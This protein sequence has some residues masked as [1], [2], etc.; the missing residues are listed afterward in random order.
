MPEGFMDDF[1]GRLR[2]PL[3]LLLLAIAVGGAIDLVL[4]R[5]QHLFSLHT[6]YEIG[7]VLGAS[8]TAVWL[9]RGWHRA[10]SLNVQLRRTLVERQAERDAWRATAERA[11]TGLG[12]AIGA[13]FEAWGLSPAEREVALQLLK[14]KSHK[15]IAGETGRSERTVR[16]HA[17]TAYEKAGLGGRA[18]LAAYFLEGLMLPTT[19]P[20]GGSA[21]RAPA[22]AERGGQ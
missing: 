8:A 3:T 16:Q 4:D 18:E 12:A 13:Q 1:N 17:A 20:S 2:F 15:E 10:D 21:E 11:L 22:S 6:I 9:W 5:P 7:L 14:G 19:P